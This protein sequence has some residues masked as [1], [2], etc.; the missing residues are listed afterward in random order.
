MRAETVQ[1]FQLTLERRMSSMLPRC[2]NE[3]IAVGRGAL[4]DSQPEANPSVVGAAHGKFDDAQPIKV[5][6]MKQ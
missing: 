6:R 5:E 3:S 1:L 4:D 2:I